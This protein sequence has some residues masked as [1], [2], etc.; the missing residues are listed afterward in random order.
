[1]T[2]NRTDA[3][4]PPPTVRIATEADVDLII[5]TAD[6]RASRMRWVW[7]LG[8]GGMF[9]EAYS[10][11]ALG[12][13]LAPLIDEL[14]LGAG[15]VAVL[16]ST[17][18]F[19]A[20]LV[21]PFAG[22]WASRYGRLPL[23]LWA[24][25]FA[26]VSA[27][28]GALAPTF[29]VLMVSRLLAGLSWALDCAV[30]LAYIGEFLAR[31]HRGRLNRWQG[32]WYIA[33]VASLLFAVGLH[34]AGVGVGIWR[35][36]LAGAGVIALLLAVLQIRYLPESPRWLAS[37]GR[38]AD[39]AA[40][41]SDVWRVRV[42]VAPD[43]TVPERTDARIG[44]LPALFAGRLRSRSILAM[45]AHTAQGLQYYAI[46]WYLP[47]IALVIFGDDFAAATLG[48]VVFNLFGVVGGMA[49]GWLATRFRIRR[50]LQVGFVGV[51]ASLLLLGGFL[52]RLPL[53]AAFALPAAFLLF[54]AG[55]AA[56]GG[57]S[58]ATYAYPSRLRTLGTGVT[59]ALA[60]GAAAVGLFCYPLLQETVGAGGAILVTALVP[61]AGALVATVIRW[62]PERDPAPTAP[63]AGGRR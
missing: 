7:L 23:I 10:S 22:T 9:F 35:W 8:L 19:V 30:V 57:S 36:L 32:I 55:G 54:H 34:T 25:L 33:T 50:C 21:C 1:M 20:L 49:S 31:R 11:A 61:A 12:A 16:T 38:W 62:D 17:S 3:P 5:D 15:H 39:A 40:V 41:L 37:R 53:W 56:S 6:V 44:D 42:E 46:G 29:A 24:K 43:A 2:G 27:V 4:A 26:V 13:G 48:A 14:G 52:T 60:S 45:V 47:V 59:M 51:C 18:M 63:A 58:L 28:V